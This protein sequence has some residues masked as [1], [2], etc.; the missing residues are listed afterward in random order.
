MCNLSFLSY[1]FCTYGY[2]VFRNKDMLCY[3]MS[4]YVMLCYSNLD[5]NQSLITYSF[6]HSGPLHKLLSQ[7]V[8]NILSN[9]A[10][11]QTERQTNKR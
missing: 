9:V 10:N 1:V 3:V 4:C 5:R 11:K 6:Y 7:S 8:H 2:L